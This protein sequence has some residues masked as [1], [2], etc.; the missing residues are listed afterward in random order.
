MGRMEDS[1][2]VYGS[3][4]E[5][6]K[7]VCLANSRKNSG[8][9]VAG[10]QVLAGRGYGGWIRPV[11][12]HPAAAICEE[13]ARYEN[14]LLPR[15]LDIIRVPVKGAAPRLHQSENHAIDAE[16][17]WSTGGRLSWGEVW[18][19]VDRPAPLWSNH[20]SS[21]HGCNDRV[22]EE[23]AVRL[24]YSLTLIDPE[25]VIVRTATEGEAY[26]KPRRRVRAEFTHVGAFHCLAV[27]DPVVEKSLLA[28]PDGEY[29][30]TDS[31]LCVSLSEPFTDGWCYKLVAAIISK[32]PL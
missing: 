7:I 23:I 13:E 20:D 15:V 1:A 17:Y 9:C 22:K 31:Y 4:P 27:T 18:Q 30:R 25:E 10:K 6:K 5:V 29:K 11:S 28:R 12:A 14:G 8:R 32:E 2:T 24:N 3:L 19:L 16:Y 21:F 26:G